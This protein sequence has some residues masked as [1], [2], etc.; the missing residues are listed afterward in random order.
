MKG[1]HKIRHI[2]L[3]LALAYV[4]P[5]A[6][7]GVKGIGDPFTSP[8]S[9]KPAHRVIVRTQDCDEEF[10][11]IW[12]LLGRMAFFRRNGYR[13]ALPE[14]TLF[15]RLS[16]EGLSGDGQRDAALRIFHEEIHDPTRYH[17]GL[18]ALEHVPATAAPVF[19]I[20]ET[21]RRD[22][23]FLLFTM[24]E[25]AL[26]LYGPGGSYDPDSGRIIL[27]TTPDGRFRT[28]H[29][30]HT[31]VH[32]MIHIGIEQPIVER[33]GL[34]HPEKERLVDRLAVVGLGHVLTDYE[35]QPM[36]PP[37]MDR[38]VTTETLTDLPKAI[39]SYLEATGQHEGR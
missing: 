9:S 36:G 24:Y 23:G 12:G 25:V 18:A 6:G 31:I 17:A 4:V 20:F 11:Y 16:E 14:H 3:C 26:T 33:L 29:P 30:V 39:E 19:D 35:P 34:S 5:G 38:F 28:P 27:L 22:W 13:V 2:V 1:S 15:A 10:A 21:W 8:A 32:E 7:C 37:E